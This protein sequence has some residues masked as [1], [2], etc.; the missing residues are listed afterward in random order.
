MRRRHVDLSHPI[1]DGMITYPG[2]P[3]PT[4]ATHLS[5]EASRAAYHDQAEFFIGNIAMCGNTGTYLDVP[6]HRYADGHDLTG[7]DLARVADVPA[8]CVDVTR[9]VASNPDDPAIDLRRIG[10]LDFE[11][12]AVLIRTGWSAH[13]GTARYGQTPAPYLTSAAAE[14]LLSGGAGVVG[15][16]SVN[17]DSMLDPRRPVHTIL[18][19]AGVPIV[20]HLTG[21]DQLPVVG[22][23]F[24]AVPPK[25][26]GLGTFTVRAYA[27]VEQ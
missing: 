9:Q 6:F 10:E 26:E 3:S 2:L 15:I 18:L 14:A 13:W 11:G 5:R 16:D 27:T 21:L 17:I 25:I 20:E 4:V 8:V 19:A 22:F 12:V 23:R 7:L 24:T 1:T